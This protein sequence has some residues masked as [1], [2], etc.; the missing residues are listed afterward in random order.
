[1]SEREPFFP[2]IPATPA[3]PAGPGPGAPAP[4]RSQPP[5]LD[6]LDEPTLPVRESD[7]D[8]SWFK[9]PEGA[10]WDGE[11]QKQM[12]SKMAKLGVTNPQLRGIFESYA[13]FVSQQSASFASRAESSALSAEHEL[14]REWGSGYEAQVASAKK[15]FIRLAGGEAEAMEL[16]QV[17]LA[18]GSRLG[19]HP[20]IVRFLAGA[21]EEMR[22]LYAF[23]APSTGGSASQTTG[24]RSRPSPE[25]VRAPLEAR[26]E[27]ERLLADPAFREAYLTR[28]HPRHDWAVRQIDQLSRIESGESGW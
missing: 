24:A 26:D 2:P 6:P 27:R 23:S 10:P 15:A 12:V 3:A 8:L 19:D 21:A 28:I 1:M 20:A 17:L 13:D 5:P 11:F 18:D 14:R 4:G 16:G 22:G 25:A 7:Y 9:P